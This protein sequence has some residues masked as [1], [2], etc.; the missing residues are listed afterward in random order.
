MG[1]RVKRNVRGRE[2]RGGRRRIIAL[3]MER[4]PVQ[5]LIRVTWSRLSW[6]PAVYKGACLPQGRRFRSGSER[7]GKT[8]VGRINWRRGRE[9]PESRWVSTREGDCILFI[10]LVYK[11]IAERA[12]ASLMPDRRQTRFC[13]FTRHACQPAM[14]QRGRKI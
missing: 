6:I 8:P 9:V 2:T 11:T 5:R 12:S 3:A 4:R 13:L 1:T 10:N 14:M 7:D